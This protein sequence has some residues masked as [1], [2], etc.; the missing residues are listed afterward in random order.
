[1]RNF[2]TSFRTIQRKITMLRIRL[3]TSS[4][5][6]KTL[7]IFSEPLSKR[8]NFWKLV[9]KHDVF[10]E[11]SFCCCYFGLQNSVPFRFEP[12]NV[13]FREQT[14]VR[15]RSTFFRGITKTVPILFCGIFSERNFNGNHICTAPSV[16]LIK[17]ILQSVL[18]YR[19]IRE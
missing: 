14:E 2:V 8:K 17:P 1:M 13:R 4:Q 18:A 16:I 6:R 10:Y 12:R 7:E 19:R 15:E 3:R 5:K 11:K 9:S